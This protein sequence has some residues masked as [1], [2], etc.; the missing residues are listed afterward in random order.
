MIV[1]CRTGGRPGSINQKKE[2]KW[3]VGRKC[4]LHPNSLFTG[5]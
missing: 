5:T 1:N 4:I 3:K 2:K